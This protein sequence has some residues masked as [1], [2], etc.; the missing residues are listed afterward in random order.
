MGLRS[1]R[2]TS[3]APGS[4][5]NGKRLVNM[6]LK[7]TWATLLEIVA[8]N[9]NYKIVKFPVMSRI[10]TYPDWSITRQTSHVNFDANK[11]QVS[12]P[13]FK[14]QRKDVKQLYKRFAQCWTV[15]SS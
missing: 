8:I 10:P 7:I 2:A 4:N 15:K 1:N 12:F 9:C 5:N 3:W 11:M 13:R 6:H 14:K